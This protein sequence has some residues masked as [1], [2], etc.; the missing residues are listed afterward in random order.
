MHRTSSWF[1]SDTNCTRLNLV[2]PHMLIAQDL[3]WFASYANC[4][5]LD[6]VSPR[7][8]I[9]QD[10][11]CYVCLDLS[12]T[13]SSPNFH[14]FIWTYL[15]LPVLQ[16]FIFFH[17]DLPLI[18]SSSNFHFSFFSLSGLTSE[19]QFGCA[20]TLSHMFTWLDLHLWCQTCWDSRL[21]E[22]PWFRPKVFLKLLSGAKPSFILHP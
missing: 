7:M 16:I 13:A 21:F 19:C 5:G 4:T 22:N 12:S 11:T 20:L 17:L 18:A 14:F 9:A 10:F 2:S 3:A 15:W 6:L 8:L 1:T